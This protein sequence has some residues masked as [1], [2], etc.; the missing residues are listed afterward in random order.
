MNEWKASETDCLWLWLSSASFDSLWLFWAISQESL[1]P[2]CPLHLH[3][4]PWEAPSIKS[5]APF[6][7]GKIK[8]IRAV[9]Q[10]EETTV[11]SGLFEFLS[12]FFKLQ[13]LLCKSQ[14]LESIGGKALKEH[15][16]KCLP[17]QVTGKRVGQEHFIQSWRQDKDGSYGGGEGGSRQGDKS[18]RTW[19]DIR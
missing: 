19:W 15:D 5:V 9:L 2:L 16:I 17:K 13:L 8:I 18:W 6:A 14:A 1:H 4:A 12:G 11:S 10:R 7:P 3:Q